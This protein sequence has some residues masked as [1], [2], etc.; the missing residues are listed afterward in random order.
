MVKLDNQITFLSFYW[1]IIR[2]CKF[3]LAMCTSCQVVL[4]INTVTIRNFII[5][6]WIERIHGKAYYIYIFYH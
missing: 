1:K 6:D 3:C 2:A 5:L 4:M